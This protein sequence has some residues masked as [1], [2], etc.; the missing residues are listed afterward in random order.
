MWHGAV[1]TLHINGIIYN[2]KISSAIRLLHDELSIGID[3]KINL[4]R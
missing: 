2:L 1:A 3:F 4:L